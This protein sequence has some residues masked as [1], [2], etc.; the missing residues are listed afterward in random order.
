MPSLLNRINWRS[1]VKLLAA[2]TAAG[3]FVVYILGTVV[4]NTQSGQGCGGTWPLCKGKFIPSFVLSTFIEWVHRVDTGIEGVLV[5][6]LAVGALVF[7]RHRLEIRILVPV[8]L[9]ILVV[10]AILGAVIAANPHAVGVLAVHFGSSLITIVSVLLT[11]VVIFEDAG[12]DA[13]RD[14]PLPRRF[15]WGVGGLIALTYLVGFIGAYVEHQSSGLA[16]PDWPLCHGA[17]VPPLSGA[18]GLAVGIVLIHRYGAL[19]LVLATVAVFLWARRTRRARPDLYWGARLAL[20]L[21]LL[22]GLA[23]AYLVASHLSLGSRLVHAGLLAFYFGT[24]SYLALHLFARQPDL[25]AK[26]VR[27]AAPARAPVAPPLAPAAPGTTPHS[28]TAPAPRN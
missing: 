7:W 6:A 17:I 14:R 16:C 19:L 9:G 23:G 13:V 2:V 24:L 10:E 3:M 12:A 8:M 11:A 18:T 21:I 15:A 4:T 26:I 5:L 27:R 20:V 25:R 28:A 1:A 22:Q